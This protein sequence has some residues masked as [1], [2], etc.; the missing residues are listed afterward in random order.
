MGDGAQ[1]E[2]SRPG[3]GGSMAQSCD[4]G[5]LEGSGGSKEVSDPA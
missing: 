2:G 1:A 4:G 3:P 5:R